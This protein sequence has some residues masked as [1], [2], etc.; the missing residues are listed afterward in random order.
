MKKHSS[1]KKA[2]LIALAVIVVL[3]LGAVGAVYGVTHGF[4]RS[5]NY[6]SDE[7]AMK[8]FTNVGEDT[9]AEDEVNPED[10]TGEV[11][12]DEE[13][14]ELDAKLAEFADSEPVTNDGNVYNV[15]LVG[16]DRRDKSW[17]GNSDSMILMSLNYEK[18]QI[19]MISLMRDTYVNIPGI[20]MR[21]LNAA[22]ANGAGPL[23][24]E[25][26]TQNYKVQVDRYVSVDFNSMIDIIDKLGGVEL[27]L[28]DDEVRVA[29]N[30]I[31][32][33]CNLRKL[34]PNSYYFI[35]G[36]TKTCSG[37]QA[38]AYARIRY[39]GNADYQRTERQRTV[40]EAM[41]TKVQ[42]SG[43]TTINNVIDEVFDD[44]ST[45]I[46]P[47]QML[48]LA[49]HALSYKMVDNSGFPFE[50]KT[51][52]M[53]KRGDCV[54]P[55]DLE[56]NV[57]ELHEYLFGSDTYTPTDSVKEKSKQIINDTGYT[58]ETEAVKI[59]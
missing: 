19:S 18:K 37:I 27:T 36:G 21:K 22:H 14:Q 53:G 41:I 46:T 13:Q 34:D 7:D 38:V 42:K 32:E 25:T 55:L 54:I 40:I 43:V 57:I 28:S 26:V 35:K 24:L 33:M 30:Y 16:V 50:L 45:N 23:L 39:V 2:L 48:S 6:T 10:A 20:G 44:I 5:S 9:T 31:T 59:Q 56:T 8:D 1:K 47:K 52:N 15:L 58:K 4:Y 3:I 17:A 11:L 29:N 49:S 12:S 51:K